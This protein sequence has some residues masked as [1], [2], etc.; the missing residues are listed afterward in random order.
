MTCAVCYRQARGFGYS[1][2]KKQPLET[3]LFCSRRCL[4]AFATL[5][6]T[7]GGD[8]IDTTEMERAA[9]Q[10]CLTPLAEVANGKGWH[11][12][13]GEYSREDILQLIEA[14]V[15]AYRHHMTEAHEAMLTRD[16]AFLESQRKRKSGALNEVPF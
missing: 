6:E 1:P 11:T 9:L 7:L 10:S 4:E 15:I 2:P 16:R 8:M 13:L 5:M 14:V 12:P 3:W